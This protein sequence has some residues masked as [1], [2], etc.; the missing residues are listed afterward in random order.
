V[1]EPATPPPPSGE[2]RVLAAW[3][4][5]IIEAERPPERHSPKDGPT[6]GGSES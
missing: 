3:A 4:E 5:I 2:K 1:S 6:D